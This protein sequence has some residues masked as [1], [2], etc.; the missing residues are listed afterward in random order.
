MPPP[1]VPEQLV[2]KS[3]LNVS[4]NWNSQMASYGSMTESGPDFGEPGKQRASSLKSQHGNSDRRKERLM[5]LKIGRQKKLAASQT[6]RKIQ[7]IDLFGNQAQ[8]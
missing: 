6:F 3:Q 2:Q 5:K 7:Y 1:P 4:K 8:K